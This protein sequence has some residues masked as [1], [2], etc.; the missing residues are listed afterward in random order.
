MD[1]YVHSVNN[2]RVYSIH[3]SKLKLI[4]SYPFIYWISDE[5]REKFK[6]KALKEVAPPKSGLA[7]SDNNKYLR[8]W[9]EIDSLKISIN[10]S[11][12]QKK[13]IIYS[14]GGPYQKWFGNLWLVLN[15]DN[16]GFKLRESGTAVLRNEEFYFKQGITYCASGA[17]GASFR[18]LPQ[19]CIYDVGGASIFITESNIG[20]SY[21]L[22]LL[23]SKL[24]SYILNC[25]NPTVNTQVGDLERIPFAK[26]IKTNEIVISSLS[27]INIIVKKHLCEFSII[28]LNFK[29]N[30]I[31]WSKNTTEYSDIKALIKNY[32][33]YENLLLTQVLIN[34]A[35]INETIFE[36]YSLSK[37]DKQ[38]VLTKE[39]VPVGSLPV[40]A[41]ARQAYLTAIEELKSK[42]VTPSEVEGQTNILANV[43][44]TY[45]YIKN[46]PS[47]EI[48]VERKQELNNLF[49]SLFQN[50]NDL[51]E[52]CI[53][54]NINPINVWYLFKQS[55]ILPSQRTQTIAM[56]L[57][58]DFIRELLIED[59][60]GIIPLTKLPG[61]KGLM[62][63]IEQ[64]FFDKDFTTA[65]YSNFSSLLGRDISSYLENNFFKNF[66][67]HL[68]LFMYL[69]KT[70]F[71][72]H[73]SSGQ[74]KAFECFIIIYKWSR[75][76]VF[77]LRSVYVDKREAVL[78]N[79]LNDLIRNLASEKTSAAMNE[80]DITRKQ[81]NEIASFKKNID[82]LLASGYSP[83]LDDGVGKNI[84]PLQQRGMLKYEVLNVG[85]LKK[86]LNADW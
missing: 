38:M 74:H 35:I 7:T 6:D 56:E 78:N 57:L 26:P 31:L 45:G 59:D 60:D 53:K 24:V 81:L 36:V 69:P 25:L 73:L 37:K 41:Q 4:K 40:I 54:Q 15:W 13:W 66:S 85:Q 83:I 49:S 43:N 28:E 82:E 65:Q 19:N 51:E 80:M 23:N 70:P 18:Q 20:I 3:Q 17:K 72:W 77:K 44:Q 61:E 42:Y 9:Y 75:D 29:N 84:A 14:K 68:N 71:I 12:D 52:F 1:Y 64:K 58:V 16:D 34:E 55:N 33:N 21:F 22:A 76:T 50:N 8:F 39:G 86:Y 67:D 5:F 62:E 30:P 47:E 2:E 46:L 32:Y 10:Y 48:S 11:T 63:L 79:R 27:T